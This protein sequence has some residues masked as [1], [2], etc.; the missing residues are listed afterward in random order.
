MV[1]KRFVQGRKCNMQYGI[2]INRL[3]TLVK[4]FGKFNYEL[5]AWWLKAKW[6]LLMVWSVLS[7]DIPWVLKSYFSPPPHLLFSTFLKIVFIWNQVKSIVFDVYNIWSH[8]GC[9]LC[10]Y[11]ASSVVHFFFCIICILSQNTACEYDENERSNISKSAETIS[12][13]CKRLKTKT[14]G[15]LTHWFSN[16]INI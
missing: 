13:K 4:V 16:F 15:S 5:S 1:T 7:V 2:L 8:L 12:M 10:F 6:A 14:S 3:T 9:K 11:R